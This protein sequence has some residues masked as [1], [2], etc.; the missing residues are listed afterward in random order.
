MGRASS[1]ASKTRDRAHCLYM[2]AGVDGSW[3]ELTMLHVAEMDVDIEA[4]AVRFLDRPG[5]DR[6]PG[7]LP[8][9]PCLVHL[10]WV[11]RGA[12]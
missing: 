6:P 11:N 5:R 8:P 12:E 3:S 7:D 9:Q 10:D 4:A 1:A 2:S